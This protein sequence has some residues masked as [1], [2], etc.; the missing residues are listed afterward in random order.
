MVPTRLNPSSLPTHQRE[1]AVEGDFDSA[2]TP[3]CSGNTDCKM[4]YG[5]TKNVYRFMGAP[6]GSGFAAV[7]LF[8]LLI[9]VMGN[10]QLTGNAAHRG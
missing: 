10:R 2:L 5:L 7:S 3:I 8:W 6:A 4:Y 9:T 1:S